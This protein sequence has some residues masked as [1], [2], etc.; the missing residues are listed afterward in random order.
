MKSA[1]LLG[2]GAAILDDMALISEELASMTLAHQS[3]AVDMV[4]MQ[5]LLDLLPEPPLARP[6]GSTANTLRAFAGLGGKAGMLTLLGDD[7]QGEYFRQQMQAAGVDCRNC[8]MRPGAMTG[9]C[10]SLVTPDGERSMYTLQGVAAQMQAAD[11]SA[12][13][14]CGYSHLFVEGYALYTPAALL[15]VLELA[16]QA[17]LCIAFDAGSPELVTANRGLLNELLGEFVSVAFFN[18]PEGLALAGVSEREAA[19]ENLARLC[20]IAVLKLGGEGAWIAADGAAIVVPAVKTQLVDTTGAGDFWAGAFL[21]AQLE[22]RS[23]EEAGA[24]AARLAAAV[25]AQVGCKM[26][27]KW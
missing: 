3:G 20:E 10:L 8:K 6:G 16:K 25:V 5:S 15:H 26:P 14:F 1:A 13:D 22:G 2:F 19:L 24:L 7:P 27:A 17:G 23:L 4:Q 9:R 18:E 21:Y 12:G 11:F